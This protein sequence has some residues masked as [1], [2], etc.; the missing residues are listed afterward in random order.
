MGVSTVRGRD[1]AMGTTHRQLDLFD[2]IVA[3]FSTGD[4]SKGTIGPI[5]PKRN[6]SSHAKRR[7]R[8]A[9]EYDPHANAAFQ[10]LPAEIALADT[11]GHLIPRRAVVEQ[12][13]GAYR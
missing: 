11:L 8:R 13:T 6:P 5:G 3:V 10:L 9:V 2:P 4:A 1:K 12:S 7:S